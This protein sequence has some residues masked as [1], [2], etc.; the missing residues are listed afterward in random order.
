M[1]TYME[2]LFGKENVALAPQV[3]GAGVQA[4]KSFATAMLPSLPVIAPDAARVAV[5]ADDIVRSAKKKMTDEAI[6]KAGQEILGAGANA[7]SAFVAGKS[8]VASMNA[9]LRSQ[10]L[11]SQASTLEAQQ[12]RARLD[13]AARASGKKWQYIGVAGAAVLGLGLIWIL[14]KRKGKR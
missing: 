8:Q 1:A 9:A 11:A 7:A 10:K 6:L 13:I 5:T 12:Q 14:A 4:T 2:L 3:W